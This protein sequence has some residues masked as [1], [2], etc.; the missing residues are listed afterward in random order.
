MEGMARI[1]DLGATLVV[2]NDSLSIE[3]ADKRALNSDWRAVGDDLR[4][5][6]NSYAESQKTED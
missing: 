6:M 5:A 1:M 4:S 2:Y 3:E